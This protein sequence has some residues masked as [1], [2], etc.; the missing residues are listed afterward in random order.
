MS[1]PP[2]AS[3]NGAAST[4]RDR[5]PHL[6]P[7]RRRPMVLDAAFELFMERGYEGTSMAAIADA[8][9]VTKPVVYACFPSK[10]KLFGT[11][12]RREEERVLQQITSALTT[13][14]IDL[15]EPERTLIEGLTAFLRAVEASPRAYRVIFLGEGAGNAA[16]IR[17]VQRGR[18][19][20][21]ESVALL[22]RTWLAGEELAISDSEDRDA[23]AR[24]IGQV[25]VSLAEAGARLLLADP[26]QWTPE[27]LGLTLG[28]LAAR[29]SDVL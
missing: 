23:Q 29:S 28:R 3:S 9:G 1:A 26:R 14:A 5:A 4:S 10:E 2:S 11:L 17:R 27:S 19:Q 8:A 6:G 16:L 24:L 20:Q 15:N 25:V 13:V 18:A 22:A 12:L 7:E 21:V